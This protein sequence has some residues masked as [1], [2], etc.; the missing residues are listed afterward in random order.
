MLKTVV[1]VLTIW[2]CDTGTIL[3]ET[4]PVVIEWERVSSAF[5]QERN[6]MAECLI[7][8]NRQAH[9]MTRSWKKEGFGNVTT[10]VDCKWETRLGRPA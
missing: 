5:P 8:G 9:K 1:L 2:N 3:E 6:R 7:E 4:D 10:F